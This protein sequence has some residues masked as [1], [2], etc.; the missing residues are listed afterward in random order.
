MALAAGDFVTTLHFLVGAASTA[1]LPAASALPLTSEWTPNVGGL[2]PSSAA[3]GLPS[4]SLIGRP[5][6]EML[7]FCGSIPS[8]VSTVA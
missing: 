2:Y 1:V 3:I 5:D 6:G 7:S 4:A 8:A